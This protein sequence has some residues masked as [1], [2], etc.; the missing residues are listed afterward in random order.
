M[1]SNPPL[2][3]QPARRLNNEGSCGVT[4]ADFGRGGEI[5]GRLEGHRINASDVNGG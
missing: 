3:R 2:P 4:G 5:E 1:K